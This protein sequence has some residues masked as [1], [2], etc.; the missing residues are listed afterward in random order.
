MDPFFYKLFQIAIGLV[1]IALL[2]CSELSESPAGKE[3]NDLKSKH[4]QHAGLSLWNQHFPTL[5]YHTHRVQWECDSTESPIYK[6]N[7]SYLSVQGDTLAMKTYDEFNQLIGVQIASESESHYFWGDIYVLDSIQVQSFDTLK[8]YA[9]GQKIWHEYRRFN[10]L[11]LMEVKRFSVPEKPLVWD[12]YAYDQDGNIDALFDM[13]TQDKKIYEYQQGKLKKEWIQATDGQA[14]DV[15]EYT[16]AE[17]EGLR[18]GRSSQGKLLIEEDLDPQ[19]RPVVLKEWDSRGKLHCKM[20]QY[21]DLHA[22]IT[23]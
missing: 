2:A 16:Y 13:T 22:E 10:N 6:V 19:G 20:Y 4:R 7:E 8:A 21:Q 5:K 15:V 3:K 11:K 17:G 9:Q 18:M 12:V 23:N 1:S 14:F